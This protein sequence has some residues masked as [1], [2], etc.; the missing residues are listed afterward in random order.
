MLARDN[1]YMKMFVHML[2]VG[3]LLD[4]KV[5]E[6]LKHFDITHMQFNVLRSLEA[7]NPATLSV[8]EIKAELI[9]PTP[10]VT[11]MLDRLEKRVLINRK[12]CPENRRKMDVSITEEGLALIHK[13][14]PHFEYKFGGFFQESIETEERDM[15]LDILKRIR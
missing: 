10:D 6:I 5:N 12:I 13:I 9:Y 1:L 14:L 15:V 11:R 7:A 8:G 2:R 4:Q 3:H